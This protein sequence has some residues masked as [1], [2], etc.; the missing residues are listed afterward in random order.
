MV[1][2]GV[3]ALVCDGI[4]ESEVG[5][6]L[7]RV[8][9][10]LEVLDFPT[11]LHSQLLVCGVADG[12]GSVKLEIAVSSSE[13]EEIAFRMHDAHL[14]EPLVPSFYVVS[15][16]DLAVPKADIYR[17]TVRVLDDKLAM[18]PFEVHGPEGPLPPRGLDQRQ[19]WTWE[20]GAFFGER[21]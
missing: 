16:D 7:L 17:F 8:T 14:F 1:P 9:G 12:V 10:R 6:D 13:G 4:Q 19:V 15:L 11:K 5:K 21:A 3:A 2:N 20:S 18:L